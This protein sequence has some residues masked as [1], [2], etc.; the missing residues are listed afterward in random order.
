MRKEHTMT[1]ENRPVDLYKALIAAKKQI[2]EMGKTTTAPGLPYKYRSYEYMVAKIEPILEEHGIFIFAHTVSM[3]EGMDGKMRTVTIAVD[4]TLVHAET[5]QSFTNRFYGKGMDSSDKAMTK[6][7]TYARKVMLLQVFG[8][9][10]ADPDGEKPDPGES[11]IDRAEKVA[12]EGY[13]RYE[14]HSREIRDS[15][16]AK[17]ADRPVLAYGGWFRGAEHNT[18]PIAWSASVKREVDGTV[19]EIELENYLRHLGERL[20]KQSQGYTS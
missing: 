12:D 3:E 18:L 6:A 17:D 11:A 10:D 14:R 7:Y 20:R 13:R 16:N 2:P 8:I 4:Y 15:E 1:S 9:A 5:G 19:Q